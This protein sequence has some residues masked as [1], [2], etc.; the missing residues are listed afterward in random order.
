MQKLLNK[1]LAQ[2]LQFGF[3][4]LI[5][6][7]FAIIFSNLIWKNQ[8]GDVF[9]RQNNAWA[10]WA[11][12]FTQ[13]SAMAH[14][15]LLLEH[16]PILLDAPF[17][18][19]FL[20]NLI[21]AVLIRAG[22]PF[23]AAFTIP[24]WIF[25]S[26]GIS[27]LLV[28]Y[29]LVLKTEIKAI[30]ATTL[31]LLNG[32]TGIFWVLKNKDKWQEATHIK[33]LGIE[34]I[35]IINS[36]LIPQRAFGLGF[37]MGIL[38]LVLLY[39]AWQKTEKIPNK[40]I[41]TCAL[42]V[43][44]LPI[45]HMHS[46]AALAIYFGSLFL[47]IVAISKP[48]SSIKSIIGKMKP[49]TIFGLLTGGVALGVVSIAYPEFSSNKHIWWKPGWLAGENQLNWFLFWWRNWGLVPILASIGMV[50]V[51][52]KEPKNLPWFTGFFTIFTFANLFALQPYLWDNTKLF[53]WVNVGFSALTIITLTK[54]YQKNFI[55]KVLCLAIFVFSIS[56]GA[57]DSLY[58][59]NFS[60]HEYMMYSKEE[61]DL[62]EW[63][64]E[65]SQLESIW[66]TS[67]THNHWLYNLTGRQP[68]MAYQGWLWSH[69][70]DSTKIAA[71]VRKMFENPIQNLDL[72]QKYQI[73]YVVISP[74]ELSSYAIKTA[75][76]EQNFKI[77][78]SSDSVIIF[79]TK[80][81][82]EQ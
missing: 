6:V 34:W 65:S 11:M 4:L 75:D 68:V 78:K 41:I 33:E 37:L 39:L 26:A 13:G 49:W 9:L 59:L 51:W 47:T 21:S 74:K 72:F 64:K 1:L 42:L 32:G 20:V 7:L 70:Y 58:T 54:I 22:V 38:S 79:S 62:S 46:F 71:D 45:V 60:K 27:L 30:A 61:L 67:D 24:S 44:G 73:N 2:Q 14:R 12:H 56:S 40:V 10:D 50:L 25:V 15:S 82:H 48:G 69:G 35:S 76:F 80:L 19:P 28:F 66:L 55:G 18:Y 57:H 31:F 81:G 77:V 52:A 17:S 36:S 23:F 53:A 5:W 43:G 63:V 16:S 8:D 3:I 29:K